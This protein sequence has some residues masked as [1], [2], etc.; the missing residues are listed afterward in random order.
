LFH[1]LAGGP[2]RKDPQLS[3]GLTNLSQAHPTLFTTSRL[4]T[5]CQPGNSTVYRTQLL[6][7]FNFLPKSKY[8]K[9]LECCTDSHPECDTIRCN[10]LIRIRLN[11]LVFIYI[12]SQRINF[13]QHQL[14]PSCKESPIS[15]NKIQQ[16][17][18]LSNQTFTLNE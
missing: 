7:L 8:P 12:T 14:D 17:Y 15:S 2:Y 16:Y 5:V 4:W 9:I 3:S 6:F 11:G 1:F 10:T 13:T 18:R